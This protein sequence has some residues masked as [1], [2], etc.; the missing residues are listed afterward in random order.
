MKPIG[1]E[2][3]RKGAWKEG[4]GDLHRQGSSMMTPAHRSAQNGSFA[5]S[6]MTLLPNNHLKQKLKASMSIENN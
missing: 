6:M 2:I 4:T 5:R 3:G 1:I